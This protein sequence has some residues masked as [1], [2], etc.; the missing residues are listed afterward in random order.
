MLLFPDQLFCRAIFTAFKIASWNVDGLRALVRKEPNAL[1]NLCKKHDLDM[2]CLQ[3]TKLQE[4]HLDDP[5]LNLRGLLKEDGYDDYWSCSTV[6]KGYSGTAV[7]IKQGEKTKAKQTSIDNFFGSKSKAKGAS[8]AKKEPSELPVS[9]ETL[10]PKEVS[11]NIG[12]E[13][14]NEGRV[15]VCDFPFATIANVYVPNSGQDLKRLSYRTSEWD[16]DFFEFMQKKEADRGLPV[17]WLGDLNIAHKSLDVW[18]DGAKHLAKQAGVTPQ[19]RASFQEQLE[20]GFID[21]FRKLHPTAKGHY[22]YWSQRAGNREPNKGLR[23]DYFI[24]SQVLFSEESKVIV[25]D[26]YMLKDQA[27]SDHGPVVLELEIKG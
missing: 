10:T 1:S 6:K 22:S 17:I 7:F 13:I 18:N 27:G 16:K 20:A 8:D 2:L 5:K 25:R 21:A 11:F 4:S 9:P 15:N 24:C 19:E 12:K 26:S 3:E 23:L 14:D